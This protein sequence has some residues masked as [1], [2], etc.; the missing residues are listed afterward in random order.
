M[1]HVT[2]EVNSSQNI[3][4]ESREEGTREGLELVEGACEAG[5]AVNYCGNVPHH[6]MSRKEEIRRLEA[7]GYETLRGGKVY[8]HNRQR[9]PGDFAEYL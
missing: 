4:F 5:V 6:L 7:I 8:K 9:K 3:W 2:R 1:R